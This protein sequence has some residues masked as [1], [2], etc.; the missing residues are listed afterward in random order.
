ML[1]GSSKNLMF[2]TTAATGIAPN[3]FRG[4]A[5][6]FFLDVVPIPLWDT[7]ISRGTDA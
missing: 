5:G 3:I 2:G 7:M 4:G 1:I 6:G